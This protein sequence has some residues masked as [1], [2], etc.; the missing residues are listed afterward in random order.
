MSNRWTHRKR[1]GRAGGE[2]EGQTETNSDAGDTRMLKAAFH[3]PFMYDVSQYYMQSCVQTLL[4][5]FTN[6]QK[7]AFSDGNE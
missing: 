3:C 6:F 4:K 5:D 7:L 1:T 2:T